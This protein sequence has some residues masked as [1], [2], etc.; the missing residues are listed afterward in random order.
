MGAKRAER[1]RTA[2]A[3]RL[4]VGREGEMDLELAVAED[5]V[6]KRCEKSADLHA[7]EDDNFQRSRQSSAPLADDGIRSD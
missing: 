4:R 7:L 5:S 3:Q 6:L 1:P 2:R